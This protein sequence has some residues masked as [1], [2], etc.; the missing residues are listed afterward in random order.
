[1]RWAD[2]VERLGDKESVCIILDISVGKSTLGGP[3]LRWKDI[4]VDNE[5]MGWEGFDWI[6]LV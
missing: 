5:E 4:D 3:W 1:M 6:N 2:H